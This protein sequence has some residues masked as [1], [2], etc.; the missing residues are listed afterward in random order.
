VKELI[1]QVA[2]AGELHEVRFWLD[3]GAET[4]PGLVWM[5]AVVDAALPLVLIQHPGFSSKD[6]YF[7]RD[8]A[9]E[10]S[11][12]GWICGGIDAP[13]HGERTEHD[14]LRLFREPGRYPEVRAQFAAEVTATI[15]A[16][17]AKLPVDLGRLAFVGYSLGS[18]LG[19]AAVARDG[20]FRAASLGLVGE[21]GLVG[22]VQ[23]PDADVPKLGEVAVR[24]IGKLRDE[25]IPR[26]A[27]EKLYHA[28]PGKKDIVWLPG[29]HYEIGPD[30]VKAAGEWVV[31]RLRR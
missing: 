5:P 20:R 9:M 31:E 23:G 27:T 11:K 26:E 29:G 8:V 25:I 4:V 1:V 12:R 30:V 13:L 19:V 17:A 28:I 18:M 6:D 10:W 16:L 22:A 15:D 21:G 2:P 3:V 24:V 7:V 14:P